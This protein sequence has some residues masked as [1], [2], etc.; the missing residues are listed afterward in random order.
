MLF[1]LA[2]TQYAARLGANDGSHF[3]LLELSS[4]DSGLAGVDF[5]I[6]GDAFIRRGD[7]F[8]D[9]GPTAARIRFETVGSCATGGPGNTLVC[10]CPTGSAGELSVFTPA[11]WSNN[12]VPTAT[13]A[14]VC[15]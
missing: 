6:F 9:F 5:F 15:N 3:L 13:G 7:V 4:F 12:G 14:C 11:T 10:T 2:P 8:Y 1:P